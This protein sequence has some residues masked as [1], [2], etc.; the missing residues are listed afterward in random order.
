[1]QAT[2]KTDARR[3]NW[4]QTLARKAVTWKLPRWGSVN[5]SP[6][7][8]NSAVN[9]MKRWS[10]LYYRSQFNTWNPLTKTEAIEWLASPAIATVKAVWDI[11]SVPVN[12]ARNLY[13]TAVDYYNAWASNR[14]ALLQE[15]IL[16]RVQ[17]ENKDPFAVLD[18]P[19]TVYKRQQQIDA[20][21]R[22]QWWD[23]Y[24]NWNLQWNPVN[25][26][27]NQLTLDTWKV[28]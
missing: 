1:M 10:N 12:A 4:I 16:N 3:M 5:M 19:N 8:N 24:N 2:G 9:Q 6:A 21:L 11:A 22:Q 13:N 25:R 23:A 15:A 14:N 26:K 7:I 17:E 18:N 20:N 28:K 27:E